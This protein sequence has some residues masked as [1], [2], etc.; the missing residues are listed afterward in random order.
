LL[1]A[2]GEERAQLGALWLPLLIFYAT[3]KCCWKYEKLTAEQ[4]SDRFFNDGAVQ[5]KAQA[6]LRKK[7]ISEYKR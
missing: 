7:E 2:T 4:I 3:S 5:R 6:H 1:A